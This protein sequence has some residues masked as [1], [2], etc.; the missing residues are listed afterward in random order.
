MA[1]APNALTLTLSALDRFRRTLDATT[2]PDDHGG[3]RV[4]G[5]PHAVALSEAADGLHAQLAAA[6]RWVVATHGEPTER[7]PPGLVLVEADSPEGPWTPIP[8]NEIDLAA[9]GIGSGGGG[10]D[11]LLVAALENAVNVSAFPADKWNALQAARPGEHHQRFHAGEVVSS[12]QLAVLEGAAK[13]LTLH[14]GD[15]AGSGGAD[16]LRSAAWFHK[17]TKGGVDAERLRAAVNDGRLKRSRKP[18][19]RWQHSIAEVCNLWP[20]YQTT[21][22]KA[23]ATVAKP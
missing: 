18:S 10:A 11:A 17:A 1:T 9:F 13:L 21:I 7:L 22:A 16:D 23:A 5:V 8:P 20:E 6:L 4:L 12:F 2:V 3:R 15:A 19:G 14:A